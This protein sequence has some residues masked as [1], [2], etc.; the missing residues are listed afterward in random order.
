MVQ[1]AY[2]LLIGVPGKNIH[3]NR[4]VRQGDP[5]SPLLFVIGFELLLFIIILICH[6]VHLID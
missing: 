5:L 2:V 4:G 6:L 1:L 3:R